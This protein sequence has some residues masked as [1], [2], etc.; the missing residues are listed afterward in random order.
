[1]G[2][3]MYIHAGLAGR[4]QQMAGCENE[5]GKTTIDSQ[6]NCVLVLLFLF[7][8]AL[9][10]ALSLFHSLLD[11]PFHVLWVH[12]FQHPVELPVQ[13][14][15]RAAPWD[16]LPWSK[17]REGPGMEGGQQF[18]LL[19]Q[20]QCWELAEIAE[21]GVEEWELDGIAAEYPQWLGSLWPC[22]RLWRGQFLC[23][24]LCEGLL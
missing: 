3:R 1:M 23:I 15:R 12:V 18:Q 13:G 11:S 22:W 7:H 20:Q 14:R 24:H 16:I 9:A 5:E 2:L 21:M 6:E 19:L 4:Q 17:I 10:L 8:D